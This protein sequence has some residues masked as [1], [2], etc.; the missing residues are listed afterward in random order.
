MQRRDWMLRVDGVGNHV[1][2]I[3]V[4]AELYWQFRQTLNHYPHTLREIVESWMRME[5]NNLKEKLVQDGVEEQLENIEPRELRPLQ[6]KVDKELAN[7]FKLVQKYYNKSKRQLFEEW[8]V[9]RIM[10]TDHSDLIEE[11]VTNAE[12]SS[13]RFLEVKL[14]KE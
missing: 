8:M 14:R 12:W 3:K 2:Q 7:D 11:W 5:V 13:N 4:D 10:Q 6:T 1:E 9:D